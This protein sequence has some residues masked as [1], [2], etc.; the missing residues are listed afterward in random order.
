MFSPFEQL[1]LM[2]VS[3]TRL[4]KDLSITNMTIYLLH[5]WINYFCTHLATRKLKLVPNR[6]Q[7]FFEII[8]SFV[9]V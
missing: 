3:H 1:K 7:S 9:S 2:F 8:Y 6:W 5:N 4:G